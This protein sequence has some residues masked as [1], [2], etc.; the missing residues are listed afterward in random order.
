MPAKVHERDGG[1]GYIAAQLNLTAQIHMRRFGSFADGL[2]H[3]LHTRPRG[4][5]FG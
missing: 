4:T 2:R 1:G 3:M 5:A